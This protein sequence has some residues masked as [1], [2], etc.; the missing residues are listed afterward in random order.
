[1]TGRRYKVGVDVGGT[2]TDLAVVEVDSGRVWR[3]KLLSTPRRPE[4]A[5]IE[6]LRRVVERVGAGQI[7]CIIHGTTLVANTIIERKGVRPAL[8][9]AEGFRDILELGAAPRYDIYDLDIVFPEPLVPRH[10]R[11]TVRERTG[12]DGGVEAS[13]DPAEVRELAR[14]LRR[15]QVQS[16]AVSLLHAYRNPANE[17]RLR[18]LVQ[19]EWPEADVSLS[20]EVAPE[21]REYERTSTVVANAYVRPIARSYLHG[22]EGAIHAAGIAGPLYV[23]LSSGGI[24]G[25]RTAAELPIRLVESGPAGGALGAAYYGRHMGEPRLVAFDIGGTTAKVC[26]IDESPAFTNA[27]EVARIKRHRPGSGLPLQVPSVELIEIGAGGGSVAHLTGTGLMQV[28]PESAGADPGPIC[29]GRGGT[30]VTVTDADLVL[31]YLSPDYFLGGRMRLDGDLARTGIARLGERLGLD[32]TATAAGVNQIVNHSMASAV[33]IHAAERGKDPTR[34]ALF[35]FGGAGPVHAYEVARVLHLPRVI[36]PLGAGVG[37]ALGFLVASLAVDLA[38]SYFGRLDSLD[39]RHVTQLYAE[40]EREAL[41]LVQES[42]VSEVHVE[43]RVDLRYVGQGF[44]VTVPVPA[45]RAGLEGAAELRRAFE[46][47]YEKVYRTVLKGRPIEAVT[48]RLRA[49]GPRQDAD[50]TGRHPEPGEP[51]KGERQVFFPEAAGY[52]TTPVYDRYRLPVGYEII[53]PAIVEEADSTAVI[54][55]RGRA[56]VDGLFNLVM[57]IQAE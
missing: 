34:Y 48:W 27:L 43:R 15:M 23:M 29:Y 47:A 2:F 1:M 33:R 5:V 40:M 49:V 38:H 31:G 14:A 37:S 44:E 55:P 57:E 41:A 35:A 53:G 24:T 13:P 26:L 56:R 45:G 36:C 8:I 12:P 16:V 6:G 22:L 46:A 11:R 42:G 9:T 39:W 32:A 3:D 54:G 17:R 20:F 50:L 51:L 7:Q 25:A 18:E 4:D 28:G 30:E 52:Q 19:A 21:I 10:L